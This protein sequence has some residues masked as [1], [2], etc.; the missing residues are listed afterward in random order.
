MQ[1]LLWHNIENLGKRGDIVEV[2]DGYAR[3]YLIPRRMASL[4]TTG[5]YR[6]F[7]VE[8]RRQDQIEVQLIEGAKQV[9]EKLAEVTSL[10]IEVNT[11]DEGIL[12]GSVTPTMI[13][14]ALLGENMKVEARAIQI[15]EPIKKI[16]T[17]EVSI[18]L[19]RDVQPKIKLWVLSTKAIK[20]EDVADAEEASSGDEA[21]DADEAAV[22]EVEEATSEE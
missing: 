14:E 13:S 18:N 17:Y 1:I 8:K 10:S 5:Q 19:H 11:N 9:E 4:P 3:N 20:L 16:G 6:E 12:Y 22:N 7:E 15:D 2:K 21:P